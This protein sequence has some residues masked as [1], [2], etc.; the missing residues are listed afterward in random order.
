MVDLSNWSATADA[1][2]SV[3]PID[4]VVNNAGIATIDPLTSITEDQFDR[5]H[6]SLS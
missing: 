4:L 2:K 1:I 5:Y 3:F 6:L